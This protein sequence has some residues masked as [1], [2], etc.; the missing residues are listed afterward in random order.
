MSQKKHAADA[1]F[2]SFNNAIYAIFVKNE[3]N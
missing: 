3:Q 2:K 1:E